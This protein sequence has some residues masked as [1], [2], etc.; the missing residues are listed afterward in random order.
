MARLMFVAVAVFLAV[1]AACGPNPEA[2]R[3]RLR[4][5]Q[6]RRTAAAA[7]AE[8]ERAAAA[9][10]ERERPRAILAETECQA[11]PL[12]ALADA[13]G[14]DLPSAR[15]ARQWRSDNESE[16]VSRTYGGGLYIVESA[17]WICQARLNEQENAATVVDLVAKQAGYS[18]GQPRP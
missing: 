3:M 8:R 1:L 5:E 10:A 4:Q 9:E 14:G 11:S 13:R 17:H 7:V 12:A 18:G 16:I 2:E 15:R 6:A